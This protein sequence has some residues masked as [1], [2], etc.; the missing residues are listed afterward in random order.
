MDVGFSGVSSGSVSSRWSGGEMD[1][2]LKGMEGDDI[3]NFV[4]KESKSSK[5]PK[6][7]KSRG[8]KG[9]KKKK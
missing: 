6:G 3:S 5:G 9:K 4:W 7:G 2:V 8:S 1:S